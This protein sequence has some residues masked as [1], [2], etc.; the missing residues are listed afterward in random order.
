MSTCV[1]VSASQL[2]IIHRLQCLRWVP[3]TEAQPKKL[4]LFGPVD[5]TMHASVLRAHVAILRAMRIP[6]GFVSIY[7]DFTTD[8]EVLE[9]YQ[10]LPH[11]RGA[12]EFGADWEQPAGL[13]G[14]VPH[15]IPTSYGTW[16]LPVPSDCP[17]AKVVRAAVDRYR[18]ALQ[19][20]KLQLR[21][22]QAV[23]QAR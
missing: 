3:G 12:V 6:S 20:P 15:L 17:M 1:V 21:F 14:R 11:W 8:L 2:D 23:V 10:G 19:L 9:A 18:R 16:V 4:N 5:T 22:T 7:S 13:Y